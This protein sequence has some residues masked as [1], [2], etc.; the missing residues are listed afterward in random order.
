MSGDF[1]IQPSAI[2]SLESLIEEGRQRIADGN[3]R[4]K[5]P[6]R[7]RGYVGETGGEAAITMP[8]QRE[9]VAKERAERASR[10]RPT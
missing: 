1:F 3:Q 8:E 9:R 2:P 5:K 10:I 7:P 4:L 6:G